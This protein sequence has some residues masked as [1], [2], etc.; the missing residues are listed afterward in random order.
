VKHPN[1]AYEIEKV[2]HLPT[3]PGELLTVDL[4]GPLPSGRGGVKYLFVCLEFFSKHVKLYPLKTATTRSCLKNL[5]DH[6]LQEVAKPKIIISDHGSQIASP[7]WQ[8]ALAE[9]GI[10]C[11]YS[12]I[13]HP[14]SNPTERVMRELGKYFKIYC[15]QTHKKWPELVLYIEKWLNNSVNQSTCYSPV[16]LLF[17]EAQPNM[18]SRILKNNKNQS[19]ETTL[20]ADKLIQAYTRMKLKAEKRNMKR[21][22]RKARWDPRL[23]ELVLVKCQTTSDA[24]Q[25]ITAKFQ[26]PFEGP[27]LISKVI[28]SAIFEVSDETGRVRGVFNKAHL[29]PYLSTDQEKISS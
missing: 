23:N 9:L 7:A 12:P 20:L 14:E 13:R 15:N 6:Y 1:R 29:R 10:Q 21:K 18:F 16:E 27:Y 28:N 24:V 3:R 8:K 11:K 5:K 4:Y 17:G 22:T 26:M 25:G 2:S 19:Q